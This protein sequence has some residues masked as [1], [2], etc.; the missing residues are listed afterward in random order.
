MRHLWLLGLLIL[1]A[2]QPPA[3]P[4]GSGG[5]GAISGFRVS[6]SFG[7]RTGIV[8]SAA[9]TMTASVPW[10]TDVTQDILPLIQHTGTL[11]PEDN[12]FT[13]FSQPV[14]YR[15]TAKDGSFVDYTASVT[16]EAAPKAITGFAFDD[17]G[18][19]GIV[20]ES[21]RTVAVTVPKGT[22]V[23]HL[24][25]TIRFTGTQVSPPSGVAE[26]FSAPVTYTVTGA[27]GLTKNY[28][29]TVTPDTLSDSKDITAF[30]FTNAGAQVVVGIVGTQ[31]GVGVL[32]GTNVTGLI[33]VITHTGV[34]ITPNPS[35]ARDFTNPVTFTVHAEDGTTKAYV[36]TVQV[37]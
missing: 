8:D 22:D 31:I 11:S 30:G 12:V 14:M 26:D 15:V 25:P 16:V 27:D 24:T 19:T 28:V 7:N 6:G 10:G 37:N 20:N 17:F 33:S 32:Q 1:A 29:V 3:G 36:V 21:Q 18:R 23:T 5:T 34:S 9:K 35:V 4:G 2:C 13:D